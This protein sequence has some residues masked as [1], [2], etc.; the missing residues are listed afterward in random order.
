MSTPPTLPTPPL[1]LARRR[2]E[3]RGPRLR[4]WEEVTEWPLAVVGVLFLV[5]YG[6]PIAFPDVGEG[7]QS[8]CRWF[9]ALTWLLFVA[10]FVVRVSL[11]RRRWLYVQRHPLAVAA[12]IVPVLR[13]LL[14]VSV[15]GR[16]NQVGRRRLRGKVVRYASVSTLL[17][18]VTSALVVTQAERGRPGSTIETLGD[19]TWWAL[20]TV[21]TVGY[22]DMAPVSPLGRTMA[23][24]LMLGGIALLGVVTATLS[25]WLIEVVTAGPPS[26]D[27]GEDHD[28]GEGSGDDGGDEGREF[29]DGG[30]GLSMVPPE[31]VALLTAEVRALRAEISDLRRRLPDPP[32]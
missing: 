12:V 4:H 19:G 32:A 21:T 3:V 29:G 15:L 16:I 10:D 9:L 2:S 14:L 17:L 24:V 28:G 27:D 31:Q 20:V 6:I 30:T 7:V 1:N 11:A 13:P 18:V 26:A 25:S 5:A 22:G 23:V 8:A